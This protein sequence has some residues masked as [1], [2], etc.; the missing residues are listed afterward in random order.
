MIG[1][2]FEAS[3]FN[4]FVDKATQGY[5]GSPKNHKEQLQVYALKTIE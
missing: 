4:S 3:S 2:Q 5:H 1:C